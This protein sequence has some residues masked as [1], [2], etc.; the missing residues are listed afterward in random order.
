MTRAPRLTLAGQYA[1]RERAA[2]KARLPRPTLIRWIQ[3]ELSRPAALTLRFVDQE[4]GLRLNRA[5]RGGNQATNV[6]TFVYTEC[7]EQKVV[8][9]ILLC[10]PVSE[11]EAVEQHKTLDAHYAHL[12]IHGALHA[13]G[14]RHDCPESARIMETLE[15]ERLFALGFADPYIAKRI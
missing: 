10:C 2:F 12:I 6:L 11:R 1:V 4:A 14:Y 9:D 7:S 13:Q 15:T 5:Y 3:G 8:S